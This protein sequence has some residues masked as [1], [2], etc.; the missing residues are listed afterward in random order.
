MDLPMDAD[1]SEIALRRG[2]IVIFATDGV[3][4]NLFHQDILHTVNHVMGVHGAWEHSDD[5]LGD[6]SCDNGGVRVS[7]SL[8]K[9]VAPSSQYSSNK[10]QSLQRQLA[11]E[12]VDAARLAASD[13]KRVS[14][15]AKGSRQAWPE[16]PW[17]GGKMD[18]I[19]VVVAVVAQ[20]LGS[21]G[22]SRL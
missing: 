2:D 17:Q 21:L 11:I 5:S 18:D 14:P 9:L 1:V 20:A 10:S 16:D 6:D 7:N 4:D 19:C 22:Q 12:L 8:E 15:F 13:T 3:W